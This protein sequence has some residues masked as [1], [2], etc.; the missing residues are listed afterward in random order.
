MRRRRTEPEED[1]QRAR[2]AFLASH[3]NS[4]Y[5]VDFKDFH[6]WILEPHAIRYIGGY[7]RMSWIEAAAW[8]SARPDP[9]A[10]YAEGILAHMNADHPDTIVA[11]CKSLTR[12]T[13]TTAAVMSGV[14]RY[15]FDMSATTGSGPRP[16]RLAFSREVGTPDQVREE[17][18]ALARR[19]RRH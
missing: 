12:A 4:S 18:V 3:P 11:Y 8:A 16:I 17:M 19:A 9:I 7:G 1:R 15:G 13:D 5:Y 2:E 14:D 10:P 6:L